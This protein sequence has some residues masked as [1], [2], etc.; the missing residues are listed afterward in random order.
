VVDSALR[1]VAHHRLDPTADTLA[2]RLLASRVTVPLPM[3]LPCKRSGRTGPGWPQTTD[4]SCWLTL[5]RQ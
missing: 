4:P 2:Q 1:A 5:R 3:Q